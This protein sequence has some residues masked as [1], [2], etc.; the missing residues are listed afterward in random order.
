MIALVIITSQVKTYKPGEKLGSEFNEEDIKRLKRLK[1]IEGAEDFDDSEDTFF[2]DGEPAEFLTEKELN[3][4]NKAKIVEYAG[5]IG[6]DELKAEM[7]KEELVDAV[8][9]Y[10]EEMENAAE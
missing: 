10:T 2:G 7:S 6:L 5:S 3:K 8:L 4:L 9:N 1:A